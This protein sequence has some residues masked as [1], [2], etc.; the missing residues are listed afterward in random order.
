MQQKPPTK[1]FDEC[2]QNDILAYVILENHLHWIAVGP[3]LSQRAGN[4]KSFTAKQI[5][6]QAWQ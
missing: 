1:L 6:S 5:I 3:E 4:F 2:P